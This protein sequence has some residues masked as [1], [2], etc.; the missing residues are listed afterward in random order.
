VPV[1]IYKKT[2]I[3]T[4][5]D[6]HVLLDALGGRLISPHILDK[7]TNDRFGSTIDA[8]LANA[9]LPIRALLDAKAGDGR[10]APRLRGA[11][12]ADGQKYNVLPGGKPEIAAPRV[13]FEKTGERVVV[14]G[15]VRSM[16]ELHR[17]AGRKFDEYGIDAEMVKAGAK[18]VEEHIP[19]LHFGLEFGP[20]FW[21]AVTKMVCNLLAHTRPSLF[22]NNSFDAVRE[23]VRGDGGDP[24]DFVAINTTPVDLGSVSTALG[25]LAHLIVVAGDSDTGTVRGFLAIYGHLQ[26]VVSLGTAL[27][28]QSFVTTYRVDQLEGVDRL[29]AASDRA[30]TPPQFIRYSETE[31]PNWLR[32]ME[33]GMRKIM[34]VVRERMLTHA[35]HEIVEKSVREGLGQPDGKPIT[36]EQ[37]DR[38]GQSVA[39]RF[40]RLLAHKGVFDDDK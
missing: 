32:A 24:W 18:V 6:E 7:T 33:T 40:V 2:P 15:K 19:M 8:A 27:L 26:F 11:N 9:L 21:R 12:T 31:F 38:V 20:G 36:Q 34:P 5:S 29:D 22:L 39:E 35:L 16:E 37:L 28:E 3:I 4:P 13:H 23:F 1:D 17:I 10:Q 25:Q 14:A 30:I